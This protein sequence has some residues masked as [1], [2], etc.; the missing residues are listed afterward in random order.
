V[1]QSE[2]D[3]LRRWAEI[4]GPRKAPGHRFVGEG[5]FDGPSGDQVLW[6]LDQLKRPQAMTEVNQP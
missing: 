3:A 2:L 1:N 6:L 5:D 4:Q